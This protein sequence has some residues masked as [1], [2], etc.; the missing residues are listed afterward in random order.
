MFIEILHDAT[1][2]IKTESTSSAKEDGVRYL[3]ATAWIKACE[4]SSSWRSTSNIDTALCSGFTD[5][6]GTAGTA[7]EVL[8]LTDAEAWNAGNVDGFDHC[9]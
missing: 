7:H 5:N 1:S 9:L 2:R 3:T 8:L 6:N 4:F